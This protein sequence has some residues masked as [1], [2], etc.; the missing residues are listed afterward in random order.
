MTILL[1]QAMRDVDNIRQG[2]VENNLIRLRAMKVD[3]VKVISGYTPD[4]AADLVVRLSSFPDIHD[5]VLRDNNHKFVFR[6]AAHASGINEVKNFTVSDDASSVLF[7][8]NDILIHNTVMYNDKRYGWVTVRVGLQDIRDRYRQYALAAALVLVGTVLITLILA[9]LV[10]HYFSRP[11]RC[12]ANF[13]REVSEGHEFSH[14]LVTKSNGEI[15]D[16]YDGVNNMLDEIE[17]SERALQR[18]NETRVR[19]II[20]S[21]LDGVISFNEAGDITYWSKQAGAIFGWNEDEVLGN[22]LADTIIPARIQAQYHEDIEQFIMLADKK[23]QSRR[24]AG[25]GLHR[26]GREIPLEISISATYEVDGWNFNVFTRDISDQIQVEK[27]LRETQ[28]QLLQRARLITVGQLTAMV[29]HELRNPMGTIQ[30]TL[31]LLAQRIASDNSDMNTLISRL[32]RNVKRC[33]SIISELLEFTRDSETLLVSTAID[34]WLDRLLNG[35]DFPVGLEVVRNLASGA[36]VPIDTDLMES[37]VL[38]AITNAV[39]AVV[40]EHARGGRIEIG[41]VIEDGRVGIV[42]SDNGPGIAMEDRERV[43]EALYSTKVYGFGLGLPTVKMIVEKHG[44]EVRIDTG[45]SGGA[46][47]TLWLNI[48]TLPTQERA[49]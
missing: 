35:Y 25:L 31:Y 4:F 28:E 13:I 49:H 40:E 10:G 17:T 1:I 26:E 29:A 6:Y 43:F 48:N 2:V 39:Q 38:N 21:G 30:N 9:I 14:R 16:L 15:G 44:G 8:S 20:E 37:A 45:P 33:D 27:R 32:V 47:V 3:F 34:G 19:N 11:I 22:S 18:L 7:G 5:V 42:I 41:T 24:M 36:R 23:S 46:R 12:L